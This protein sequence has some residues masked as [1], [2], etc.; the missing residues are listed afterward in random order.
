MTSDRQPRR[1]V[2]L[3][4]ALV[5]GAILATLV[6]VGSGS[7]RSTRAHA[8]AALPPAQPAT[9][10][11]LGDL[12][13]GM[14]MGPYRVKDVSDPVDGAVFVHVTSS[15]AEVTYEVRLL[16]ERPLPAA[17]TEKYAVYYRGT[18]GGADVLAGATAVA[19]ALERAPKDTP[20]LSGLTQYPTVFTSL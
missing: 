2:A 1:R 20:P 18:D 5:V 14:A 12:V 7:R 6:V 19:A 15:G 16:S 3:A 11:A 9:L 17:K 8:D 4:T 13:P 10:H